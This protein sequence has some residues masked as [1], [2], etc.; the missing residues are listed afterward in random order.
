MGTEFS[1]F[2][3]ETIDSLS[4]VSVI[5]EEKCHSITMEDV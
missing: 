2:I 1:S 4:M 5:K 3:T